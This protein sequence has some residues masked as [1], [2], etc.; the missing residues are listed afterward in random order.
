MPPHELLVHVPRD[1]LEIAATLLGEKQRQEEDLEEQV[2]ELVEQLGVV[3]GE[4]GI[5]NLVR[6]LDCVRD[7]RARVL[8]AVPRT[9]AAEPLCQLL[10]VEK[11]LREISQ[12]CWS[13]RSSSSTPAGSRSRT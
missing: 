5:R 7:D 2:A 12:W 3:V 10:K 9:V 11:G 6:L 8:L 1:G 13:S 4:R